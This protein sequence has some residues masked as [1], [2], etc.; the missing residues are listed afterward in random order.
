MEPC[1][2]A[3]RRPEEEGARV[4]ISGV[5]YVIGISC[6]YLVDRIRTYFEYFWGTRKVVDIFNGYKVKEKEL[7]K[8]QP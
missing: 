7:F 4:D 3:R 1:M 5:F 2:S 8:L 6:K